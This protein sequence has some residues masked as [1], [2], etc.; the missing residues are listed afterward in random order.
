[1]EIRAEIVVKGKIEYNKKGIES[2][3]LLLEKK[4][5]GM[6]FVEEDIKTAKEERA[7]LNKVVKSIDAYRKEVVGEAMEPVKEFETFMKEASKRAATLSGGIG[8]QIKEFEK[9]KKIERLEMVKKYIKEI[10]DHKPAYQE[11]MD[12]LDLNEAIFTNAGSFGKDGEPGTK[13]VEYIGNKI[14]QA[15]E[16]LEARDIQEKALQEKKELIVSQC[17][18][19]SEMLKLEIKLS[20]KTFGYLKEKSLSD[21]IDEINRAGKEQQEKEIAVVERLKLEAEKKAKIEQEKK[22]S[23]AQRILYEESSKKETERLEKQGHRDFDTKITKENSEYI[24]KEMK[25]IKTLEKEEKLFY[26]SLGF[27]GITIEKAKSF[28]KFLDENNISYEVIS[29]EVK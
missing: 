12:Q 2:G 5:D 10:T 9:V 13:L 14:Y 11:F 17:K 23:D 18:S 16:V 3:L 21:I 28:R 6:L 19:T 24:E 22:N 26:G 8:D 7:N 20:S 15:D 29:Q 1:M 27:D 25:E 4:Y